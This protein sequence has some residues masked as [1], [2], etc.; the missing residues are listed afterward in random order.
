L[1]FWNCCRKLKTILVSM[2]TNLAGAISE[3]KAGK[4]LIVV[5]DLDRENEGDLVF[6]AEFVDVG[7]INFMIKEA[8]G[9]VCVPMKKSYAEKL[10]LN[11]MVAE[12]FNQEFT[13]CKFTVSLDY[14][15]VEGSG[16]SAFDRALT[17]KNLAKG[18]DDLKRE[19]FVVPGHVFPLIAEDG[20]LEARNGHTEAAVF[21]AEQIGCNPVGVIC[22]IIA[23][24]GQMARG[25]VL[26][27][28][29]K[30]HDLKIVAIK[31]LIE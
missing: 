7:K 13:K 3:L 18:Y 28:F 14:K 21:L 30:K 27:E 5:D 19:D 8:R 2:Y 23:D 11:L 31:D 6:P 22:E 20:G 16:I 26:E 29:A 24:D 10:G 12:E 1:R 15:F 4:M 25:K 17:I 9:L